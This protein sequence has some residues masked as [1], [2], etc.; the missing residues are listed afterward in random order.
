MT[1][2]DLLLITNIIEC[3]VFKKVFECMGAR[4]PTAPAMHGHRHHPWVRKGRMNGWMDRYLW[5]LSL[6]CSC[7]CVWD[8][9]L[10][11]GIEYVG[12]N[13]SFA[14]VK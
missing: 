6:D 1:T 11:K 7:G 5:Y 8:I 2:I 14:N 9:G 10:V 3:T 12:V 13:R 4:G